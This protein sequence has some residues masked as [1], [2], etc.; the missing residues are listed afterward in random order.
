MKATLVLALLGLAAPAAAAPARRTA[1]AAVN[2][3][4]NIV[5][6]PEGGFR[7]GNPGARVKLVEYG[8]LTCVH[9]AAFSRDGMAPLLATYVHSGKVSYEYRNFIL[10]GLDV[11]ATLVARCGGPGRFFP[12]A[13]RLYA[14]RDQWMG[15]AGSL[16]AAQKAQ[17][18]ALPENQRLGRLA[19]FAGITQIAAQQ[20]I[21]PV[22]AKR[23]LTDQAG[24][25]R[26]TRMV[27]AAE[28]LGV[29]GTPT[30]FINGANIG[31]HTWATLE[32]ILRDSAG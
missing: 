31:S 32:P 10:N 8:S 4:R 29:G 17:L 12:V 28:A 20:G 15:R 30:F 1:P 18:K 16:T 6:T 19:E 26:L 2:W 7:M 3:S 21:A 13:D 9:C 14:T 22:Q 27:E 5:A 23:C 24:L 11:A 25:D